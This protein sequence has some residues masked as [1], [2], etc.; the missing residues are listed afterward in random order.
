MEKFQT[1]HQCRAERIS[2]AGDGAKTVGQTEC[3][4]FKTK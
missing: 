2:I 4:S 3:K 1:D